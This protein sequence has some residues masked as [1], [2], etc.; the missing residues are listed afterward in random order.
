MRLYN[1]PAVYAK[2]FSFV[3][4]AHAHDT[5]RSDISNENV[6]KNRAVK[7]AKVAQPSE[8]VKYP[9]IRITQSK[10][11]VVALFYN[12]AIKNNINLSSSE[13]N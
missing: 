13:A 5:T 1:V 9:Y 8:P 12:T 3:T 4:I 10:L 6:I 7:E 11:S 2:T